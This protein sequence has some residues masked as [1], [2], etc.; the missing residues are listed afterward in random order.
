MSATTANPH[1]RRVLAALTAL[2]ALASPSGFATTLPRSP[3]P[4]RSPQRIVVLN[5]ELTETLLALGRAPVGIPLPD[6][7]TSG[8]VAPPLPPGVADVGLLYQPNFDVLL[9]LAPDLL[10]V[11]PAHA[12]LMTP[13]RRIAPTLTLGAYMSAAQPFEALCTETSTMAR[14]LDAPARATALIAATQHT[15]STAADA[16]QATPRHA[17]RAVIVAEALDERHFRVYGAGS[18]FDAVLARIGLRNAANP[19]DAAGRTHSAPWQTN[20]TGSATVALQRLFDAPHADILLV[21]PLHADLRAALNASP[22]WRA[23]PAVR[24]RRVTVLP[25]IAAFGGLVSMQ[26]FAAAMPVA[27]ATLDNGGGDLA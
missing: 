26:R 27:L 13:L 12:A 7:Y 22:L 25:V 23:L 3:S 17:A 8:I 5:W 15:F 11:T 20:L 9:A 14:A 24:E 4:Q 21:G 19:R 18:L 10:I 2:A 6:W 1:R 16:I